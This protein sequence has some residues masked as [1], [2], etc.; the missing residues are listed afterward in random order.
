MARPW[1]DNLRHPRGNPPSWVFGV[2]WPILYLLMAIS[3]IVGW[4]QRLNVSDG[5]QKVTWV[6]FGLQLGLNLIWSPIF[7]QLQ[8][9][10]VALGVAVALWSV[11][12]ATMVMLYFLSPW[13][14]GLWFPYQLW[15]SLAIYL[16]AGIV[17]LNPR[18]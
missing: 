3:L 4:N 16:N 9:P 1:Y 17:H 12:L 2:V 11:S 7:F 8:A 6:L 15:L 13:S 10:R 18:V 14:F 5:Q